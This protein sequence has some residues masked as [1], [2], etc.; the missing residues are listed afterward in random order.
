METRENILRY[1][2]YSAY[3]INHALSER[4]G[5]DAKHASRE[6]LSASKCRWLIREFNNNEDSM[7]SKWKRLFY[8]LNHRSRVKVEDFQSVEWDEQIVLA[9][10]EE[11][12]EGRNLMSVL[13][14]ACIDY[15]MDVDEIAARF[16]M[17]RRQLDDLTRRSVWMSQRLLDAIRCAL[18]LDEGFPGRF[19]IC[20]REE[21]I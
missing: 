7:P 19:Q 10:Y 16:G 9:Y 21:D 15:N 17:N 8:S 14:S 13:R 11:L 1:A 18:P 20:T 12:E 6:D 3:I 2:G 5:T 4:A